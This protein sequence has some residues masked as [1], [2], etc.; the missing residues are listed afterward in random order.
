MD[1]LILKLL[2]HPEMQCGMHA[3]ECE[4]VIR[5]LYY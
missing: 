4:A 3:E 1:T 2:Y 5:E